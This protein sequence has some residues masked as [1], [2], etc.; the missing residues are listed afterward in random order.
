MPVVLILKWQR[1]YYELFSPEFRQK[2]PRNKISKHFKGSLFVFNLVGY[3]VSVQYYSRTARTLLLQGN[4]IVNE[5][6]LLSFAEAQKK[7]RFLPQSR[8]DGS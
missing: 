2:K 4:V 8:L 6:A 5:T 3:V 1:V 7:V